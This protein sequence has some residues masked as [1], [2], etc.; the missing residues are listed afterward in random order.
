M[1]CAT[2]GA[3]KEGCVWGSSPVE[4]KGTFGLPINGSKSGN[5]WCPSAS[6]PFALCGSCELNKCKPHPL[7]PGR[8][9]LTKEP[10]LQ[11]RKAARAAR[12][13]EAGLVLPVA[14]DHRSFTGRIRLPDRFPDVL[15]PGIGGGMKVSGPPENENAPTQQDCDGAFQF[16]GRARI[17]YEV[18][19]TVAAGGRKRKTHCIRTV[20][21]K[22]FAIRS[23]APSRRAWA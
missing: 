7:R 5:G 8:I 2:A 15:A 6:T 11:C 3:G 19:R 20:R 9:M 12:V 14:A 21:E 22:G 1:R 10:F 17:V 4:K 23:Q 13:R 18:G 16:F